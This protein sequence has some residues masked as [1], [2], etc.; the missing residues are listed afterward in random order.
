VSGETL[1]TPHET[2]VANDRTQ[3]EN[4]GTL[5]TSKTRNVETPT[6]HGSTSRRSQG[7]AVANPRTNPRCKV[8]GDSIAWR[9]RE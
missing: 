5:V 7:T 8:K 9:G 3:V 2:S 4:P 6:F 1:V